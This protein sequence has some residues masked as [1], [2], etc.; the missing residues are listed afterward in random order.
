MYIFEIEVF[1]PI[2][3]LGIENTEKNKIEISLNINKIIEKMILR[4]P[5]QWIWTHNRWK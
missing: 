4:D 5:S 2:K 1:N 3:T